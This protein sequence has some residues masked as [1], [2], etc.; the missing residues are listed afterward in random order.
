MK[1]HRFLSVVP[2][3]ARI[4]ACAIVCCAVLI[5]VAV[6][7]THTSAQSI[8]WPVVGRM[9]AVG[10]GLLTGSLAAVW[11][12]CLGYVYADARVRA[13]PAVLWTVI[14]AMVPNLLGFLL[15]FAL[16]KPTQSPCPRCGR[17]VEAGQRFCASCGLELF[18]SAQFSPAQFSSASTGPVTQTPAAHSGTESPH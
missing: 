18:P 16:R 10:T 15:Y 1:A 8:G 9:A 17:P 13:M 11:V 2:K 14:A 7:F 12:L 5:G 3:Q 6:G 4:A